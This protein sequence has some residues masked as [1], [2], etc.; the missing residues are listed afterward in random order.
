MYNLD[1]FSGPQWRWLKIAG[2]LVWPVVATGSYIMVL[3]FCFDRVQSLRQPFIYHTVDQPQRT[4]RANLLAAGMATSVAVGSWALEDHRQ[5]IP[6]AEGWT[7]TN[8]SIGP[9]LVCRLR[10][11]LPVV[12]SPKTASYWRYR[13]WHKDFYPACDDNVTYVTGSVAMRLL[14][15]SVIVC[16]C[17]FVAS[18]YLALLLRSTQR[19][20]RSKSAGRWAAARKTN[21][22]AHSRV[23][24]LAVVVEVAANVAYPLLSALLFALPV[25]LLMLVI[26]LWMAFFNLLLTPLLIVVVSRSA[27]QALLQLPLF[28]WLPSRCG[29]TTKVLLP[30]VIPLSFALLLWALLLCYPDEWHTEMRYLSIR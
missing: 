18:I 9:L 14:A 16:A 10:N 8:G 3:L 26:R 30:C 28:A 5:P 25:T 22:M 11:L 12:C 27:R 23:V 19:Q 4:R 2:W 7:G 1:C 24:C 17:L 13:L 21:G 29:D 6:N 15:C 20:R